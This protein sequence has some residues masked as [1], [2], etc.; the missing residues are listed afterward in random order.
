MLVVAGGAHAMQL[1]VGITPGEKLI[2]VIDLSG[3]DK[4]CRLPALPRDVVVIK[5]KLLHVW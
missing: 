3:E 5:N 1:S 2:D 4:K